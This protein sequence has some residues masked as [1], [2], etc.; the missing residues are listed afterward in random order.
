MSVSTDPHSPEGLIALARLARLELGP[1]ELAQLGAH[2]QRILG[3]VAE[4]EQV[5]V[6]GVSASAQGAPLA[7]EAL[8][9]DEA[10]PSLSR[11]EALRNAPA[12]DPLGFLVPRVVSE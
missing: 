10:R 5:P 11:S 2:L 3:W 9:A 12:C 8:R 7:A 6:E 1:D 4:L